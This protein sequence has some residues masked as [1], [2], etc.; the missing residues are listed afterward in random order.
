MGNSLPSLRRPM[1]S[2]PVPICCAS[3]SAAVRS[4]VGDQPFRKA[5]GNDVLDFLAEQ[6]VAAVSELFLRLDIQQNDLA[7][8]VHHHHG[9][10]RRFQQPAISAPICARC[11][12][13]ALRTLMSRMAAV[14]SV[15]SALS[16]G[17]SMISMGTRCHPCAAR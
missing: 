16:S 3:A 14:T 11:F 15:P 5:L 2:I 17:L 6:F 12:S 4:T 8:L 1:S 9:I 7:A 13:A 10:R